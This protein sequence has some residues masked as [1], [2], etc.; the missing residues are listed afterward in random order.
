MPEN[1]SPSL[2][3]K[4][5]RGSLTAPPYGTA[6]TASAAPAAGPSTIR[7]DRYRDVVAVEPPLLDDDRDARNAL[8]PALGWETILIRKPLC[9]KHFGACRE[10]LGSL[11]GGEGGDSNP[12]KRSTSRALLP[13]RPWRGRVITHNNPSYRTRAALRLKLSDEFC[14]MRA[15]R[16]PK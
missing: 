15:F 14:R 4:G 13:L 16:T 9:C 8:Q 1:R 5:K 7:H 11:D 6:Q 10:P 3:K 2:I 12:R